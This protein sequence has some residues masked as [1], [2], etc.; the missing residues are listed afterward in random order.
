MNDDF[1]KL[2]LNAIIWTAHINVPKDG[3][4][5][6]TPT[7]AELDAVRKDPNNRK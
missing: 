7:K 5:S 4:K 6:P 3:V 2:V 1:R